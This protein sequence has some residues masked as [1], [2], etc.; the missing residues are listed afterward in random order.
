MI[1]TDAELMSSK[2]SWDAT[3]KIMV[4]ERHY[5]AKISVSDLVGNFIIWT[6]KI[7]APLEKKWEYSE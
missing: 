2:H 3:I 6:L 5:T 7:Y 4:S 1:L